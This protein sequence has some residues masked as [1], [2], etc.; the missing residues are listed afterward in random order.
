MVG[1]GDLKTLHGNS[2]LLPLPIP[3]ATALIRVREIVEV[4]ISC[5]QQMKGKVPVRK[6]HWTPKWTCLIS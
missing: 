3:P 2:F 1:E 5:L 4:V 6:M